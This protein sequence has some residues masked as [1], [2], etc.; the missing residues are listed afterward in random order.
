MEETA[1]SLIVKLLWCIFDDC[2][3]VKVEESKG[4][5]LP[6]CDIAISDDS[7]GWFWGGVNGVLLNEAAKRLKKGE[8]T[9]GS[10]G[11]SIV[12]INCKKWQK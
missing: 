11:F 10:R 8:G 12:A 5:S 2:G 6:E 4:T 1:S 7:I 3:K 9:D